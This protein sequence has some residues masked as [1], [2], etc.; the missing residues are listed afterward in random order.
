MGENRPAAG[1]QDNGK[2]S[3]ETWEAL[4]ISARDLLDYSMQLIYKLPCNM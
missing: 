3:K 1:V 4:T 2:R